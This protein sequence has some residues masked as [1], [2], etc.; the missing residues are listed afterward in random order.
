MK[1][2]HRHGL[3]YYSAIEWG[4]AGPLGPMMQPARPNFVLHHALSPDVDCGVSLEEEVR[5]LK[6]INRTHLKKFGRFGYQW[7]VFQSGNVYEGLGWGRVGAHVANNNS[8]CYGLLFPINGNKHL[9]TSAAVTAA[10]RVI[11]AGVRGGYLANDYLLKGHRDILPGYECP[12]DLFYR[13]IKRLFTIVDKAPPPRTLKYG[14]EG[15]DVKLLQQLL[16]MPTSLHT[17]GFYTK[18]RRAVE[19]FQAAHGLRVDGVVGPSTWALLQK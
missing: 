4:I 1:P 6:G 9:P 16:G 15:E 2:S 19:S 11:D 14:D 3:T 18:T 7:V 17:G 5:E 10:R 12:G 8:K 13:E